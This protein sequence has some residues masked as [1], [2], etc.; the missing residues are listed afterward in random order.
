MASTRA[1]SYR[2]YKKLMYHL[3]SVHGVSFKDL[4]LA[5]INEGI[6]YPRHMDVDATEVS[7]ISYDTVQLTGPNADK[8]CKIIIPDATYTGAPT[9]E[10]TNRSTAT[11]SDYLTNGSVEFPRTTN[12][13][14][15]LKNSVNVLEKQLKE[16]ND[17]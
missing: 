7:F 1:Y 17:E 5:I 4:F 14:P 12:C 9:F 15:N 3:A 10:F 2:K 13:Y 11:T 8:S 16:L 6:H